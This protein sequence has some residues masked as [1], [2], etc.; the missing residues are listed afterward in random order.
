MVTDQTLIEFAILQYASDEDF[1]T[2]A[3]DWLSKLR[4]RNPQLPDT[5]QA[6]FAAPVNGDGTPLAKY[7]LEGFELAKGKE[8]H[9][10][11]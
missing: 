6:C 4:E 1:K 9:A 2:Y 7:V 5:P 11:S 8:P 3:D 10:S